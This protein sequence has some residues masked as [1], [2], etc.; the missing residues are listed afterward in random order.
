M[1]CHFH[2]ILLYSKTAWNEPGA[3]LQVGAT[4]TGADTYCG[5]HIPYQ[6]A[7]PMRTCF[8]EYL[9]QVPTR[10]ADLDP[11]TIRILT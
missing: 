7:L 2:D 8:R 6:F 1:V 11:S 4:M 3:G 10:G 9:F 5:D